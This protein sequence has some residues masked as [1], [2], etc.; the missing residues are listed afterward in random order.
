M[1]QKRRLVLLTLDV[2]AIYVN[3]HL[4]A[5]TLHAPNSGLHITELILD[6][7]FVCDLY[8][9]LLVTPVK[10]AGVWT[11]TVGSERRG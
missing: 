3:K 5:H 9:I 6:I 4:F 11:E 7:V 2:F 1:V 8:T 10:P